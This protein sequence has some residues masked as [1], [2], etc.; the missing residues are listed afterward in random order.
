MVVLLLL[1]LLNEGAMNTYHVPHLVRGT[2]DR[3]IKR[4]ATI[5]VLVV[6]NFQWKE[7]DNKQRCFHMVLRAMK[8]FRGWVMTERH[9]ACGHDMSVKVAER[10]TRNLYPERA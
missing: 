1:T 3:A 10:N 6:I 2:W 5:P 4:N 8:K 7:T 9:M